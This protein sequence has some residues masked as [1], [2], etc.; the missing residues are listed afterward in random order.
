LTL[1]VLEM[2]PNNPRN[3]VHLAI[4]CL[5]CALAV[6]SCSSSE[7]TYSSDM[8]EVRIVVGA[9]SWQA[10]E[11]TVLLDAPVPMDD[12]ESFL[13]DVDRILLYAEDDSA[14]AE[15][16]FV[17]ADEDSSNKVVVFDAGEQPEVDNEIDLVDLSNLSDIISSAVVPPGEYVKVA[18]EISNPRLMLVGD[19]A[20]SMIDLEYI[21]DVQLTANGRLFSSMDLLLVGGDTANLELILHEI[22]LVEKGGGGFVLTP[23]L[24]VEIVEDLD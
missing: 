9:G 2:T 12:V 21:T 19:A 15:E 22:H 16:V 1:E 11:G 8:A 7:V 17:D 20:E 14:E 18:L 6:L 24:R 10:P 4:L 23:Q 5:A 13:I 3:L